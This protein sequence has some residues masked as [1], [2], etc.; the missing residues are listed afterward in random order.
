MKKLV[1][2]AW[3]MIAMAA[4]VKEQN[5]TVVPGSDVICLSTSIGDLTRSTL[6][7][8]E[9]QNVQF[10]AGKEIFVEA[11]K[12]GADVTYTTGIYTTAAEGA[13][14]G[15]LYYPADLSNIDICAFY[16]A[17]VNSATT[18]FTVGS[19]Q[20]SVAEYQV[21][22]LMYATKL[23]NKAKGT[24]HAL[25]FHHALAKVVVNI[26]HGNE[27][28]ADDIEAF[29]TSVK[30]NNTKPTAEF[31]IAAGA[32][33]AITASGEA[34]DIEIVGTTKASQAGIVVPQTVPAGAFITVVYNGNNYVY[35][36]AAEQAFAPGYVYTYTLTL[37]TAG[38]E[39]SSSAIAD[40]TAGVGGAANITL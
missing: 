24:I 10:V 4:C 22:D 13:M 26:V 23:E 21:N 39:L 25:T 8:G 9:A 5:N 11:Y 38:I 35:N 3:A 29:V 34:A 33:G 16:P 1:I 15:S 31:A 19:T 32:P 2:L 6:T 14:T 27:V 28:T 36:L 37:S 17:A 7:G 20:S 30:I 18:S 40:W 12:A